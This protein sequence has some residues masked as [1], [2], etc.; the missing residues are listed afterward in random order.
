MDLTVRRGE[1]VAIIGPSGCGKSTFLR[2][3]A[4]LHRSEDTTG[5]LTVAGT[6][7]E[8]ARL[9]RQVA[10]MFQK[11]ALLPWLSLRD[12]VQL[13]L[14]VAGVREPAVTPDEM[15]AR[16]GLQGFER[17]LP[18]QCSGGMQQR[19][20]L[21]RSLMLTPD[22]VLMDEPFAAVD[23]ITRE[24]LNAQ[25]L[26][27]WSSSG[28]AVLFVTHSLEEAVYLADRVVV[29]SARP[30]RITGIVEVDLDRPRRP[31]LRGTQQFLALENE[32][33]RLLY[34]G[35]EAHDEHPVAVAS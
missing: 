4:D 32:V 23:E 20:A 33:R 12:N 16:V 34:H 3:V 24:H 14:T 15:L 28:S 9:A 2:A 5:D 10:F 13:P 1:F 18:R 31:E 21:A 35:G 26:D 17:A 27:I 30:A 22:V 19:A 6:S 11:P 25:L 29:M 7:P 8:K